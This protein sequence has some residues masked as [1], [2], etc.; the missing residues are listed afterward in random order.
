MDPLLPEL[1]CKIRIGND[2]RFGNSHRDLWLNLHR[3]VIF[4]LIFLW[5]W[6]GRGYELSGGMS[7][8]DG[9]YLH[10]VNLQLGV[11]ILR[12]NSQILALPWQVTTA[13]WLRHSLARTLFFGVEPEGDV[14]DRRLP[15]LC[16][17]CFYPL[18][19]TQNFGNWISEFRTAEE[20][21]K[22][23]NPACT[24]V[25]GD[26]YRLGHRWFGKENY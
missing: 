18:C 3:I 13:P 24:M 12:W 4:K 5:Q 14:Q 21:G 26:R 8:P 15:G 10:K 17:W 16:R 1:G 22:W 6:D 9:D 20:F 23:L 11:N 19:L 7:F 25:T 2:F